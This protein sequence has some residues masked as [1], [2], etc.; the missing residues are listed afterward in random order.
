MIKTKPEEFVKFHK[1]L[2]SN[3][4]NNYTPWY[5]PVCEN[6]KDP[7]GLENPGKIHED[8]YMYLTKPQIEIEPGGKMKIL[9][10]SDWNPMDQSNY[11]KDLRARALRKIR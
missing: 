2:M 7:D 1:L 4:P 5:F 9:F 11:L 3:A 8:G 6:G 10:K